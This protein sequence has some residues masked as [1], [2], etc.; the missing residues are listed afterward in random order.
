MTLNIPKIELKFWKTG[1]MRKTDAR[2]IVKITYTNIRRVHMNN[3]DIN[4][5]VSAG[6]PIYTFKR[7]FKQP[8]GRRNLH[9][10]MSELW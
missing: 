4:A 5:I 8:T 10:V 1:I 2:E 7:Q 9:T 6:P 3:H